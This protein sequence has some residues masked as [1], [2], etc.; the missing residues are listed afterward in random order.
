ML[1]NA[2]ALLVALITFIL[3]VAGAIGLA[4]LIWPGGPTGD[5][6]LLMML[7]IVAGVVL[8]A[9]AAVCVG[10]PLSAL[11]H[12]TFYRDLTKSEKLLD[13][14]QDKKFQ[15]TNAT[16][17]VRD[18]A[19]EVLCRLHK[20]VLYNFI[21]KRWYCYAPDGS[22]AYVAKEDSIVLSLLRRFLG[23]MFGILRTNYI[24]QPANSEEV[25]GEFNRKFT[26]F[27]RYVLDLSAD[28]SRT[29]DRRVALAIGVML[30]TGERR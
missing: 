4:V 21:R 12:V 14:L 10:V 29:L 24:I 22:L 7:L 2:G 19:G 3:C 18:R 1:Q 20:N 17:T 8:G 30:D 13:I 26:L 23:P 9:V 27:D 25:I 11:R 6:G 28:P 16:F 15:P 5:Q